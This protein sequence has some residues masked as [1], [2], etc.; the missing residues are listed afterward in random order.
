DWRTAFLVVAALATVPP[1]LVVATIV[2]DRPES[3]GLQPYGAGQDTALVAATGLTLREAMRWP[4]FWVFA[5]VIFLGGMPCYSHNKHIL[6]FLKELG[7]SAVSAAD[8]KSFYFFVAGCSRFLFGWLSD[9]TDKRNLLAVQ[10]LLIAGG[11]PLLF[12]VPAHREVLAPALV[13]F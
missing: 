12:L 3:L 6:V 10:V 4:P 2:R 9:R 8:Y 5:A 11:F 1:M 7:F 13:L